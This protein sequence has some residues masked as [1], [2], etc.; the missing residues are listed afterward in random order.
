MLHFVQ[1][2]SS[3][4]GWRWPWFAKTTSQPS[5]R[6]FNSWFFGKLFKGIV[7]P[8]ILGAI[9]LSALCISSIRRLARARIMIACASRAPVSVSRQIARASKWAAQF[10]NVLRGVTDQIELW[11]AI[12]A[13]VVQINRN[14]P[15][16]II[17]PSSHSLRFRAVLR[18]SSAGRIRPRSGAQAHH[19][20]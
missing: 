2:G 19:I 16:R 1:A 4:Q 15:S 8:G 11:S 6:D 18:Q 3:M 17:S 5:T 12:T 20:C 13:L 14:A 9:G 10:T 7:S